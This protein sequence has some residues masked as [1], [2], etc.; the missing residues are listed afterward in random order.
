M[1]DGASAFTFH[2]NL[3]SE[4]LAH[5]PIQHR[6]ITNRQDHFRALKAY[7]E[8]VLPLNPCHTLSE[9][10]VT[11][12]CVSPHI[13]PNQAHQHLYASS[14]FPSGRAVCVWL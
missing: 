12:Y 5:V 11:K 8:F 3:H 10:L 6:Q 7:T 2:P 14:L 4:P 9:Q 1:V 13:N